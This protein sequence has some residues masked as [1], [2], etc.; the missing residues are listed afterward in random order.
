VLL[1]NIHLDQTTNVKEL[2]P[3]RKRKDGR[4]Y[5]IDFRLSELKKLS[6][7]DSINPKTGKLSYP[8]RFPYQRS[9]FKI[10][11]LRE[12]IELVQGLNKTRN[13]SIGIYPEIKAPEFH[14]K[15]G[16]D[17]AKIVLKVLEEYGY[18]QPNGNIYLQ[19][20]HPPTL[21]RLKEELG[22]KMP[23]VALLAENS[24]GESSVDYEFYKSKAGLEEIS[25][26]A[27]GIGPWFSQLINPKTMKSSGL[28][29]QAHQLGLVVHPFTH[30]SDKLPPGLETDKKFFHF[31]YETLKADGI[32]SDFGDRALKYSR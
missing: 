10:P 14:L 2:Y 1:H 8:P 20:F 6:V 22:A 28:V 17:I 26:Y 13:Q 15:Q 19:C 18:N 16:K 30:R 29:E 24:W 5:V 7:Y 21:K 4:Y 11:T 12:F 3:A 31:L 32:F 9:S 27:S 25:Q 23:L